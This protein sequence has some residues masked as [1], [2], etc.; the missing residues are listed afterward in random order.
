[1]DISR[2]PLVEYMKKVGKHTKKN[3]INLIFMMIQYSFIFRKSTT[4]KYNYVLI[5]I[6]ITYFHLEL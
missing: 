6:F 2:P 3:T 4:K 5:Q 1:M